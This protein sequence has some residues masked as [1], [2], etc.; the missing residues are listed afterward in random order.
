MPYRL[1]HDGQGTIIGMFEAGKNTRT[2]TKYSLV[3]KSTEDD[4]L[5]E[6]AKLAP[7][8]IY[9][10]SVK[11]PLL[12]K[13]LEPLADNQEATCLSWEILEDGSVKITY[14][15]QGKTYWRLAKDKVAGFFKNLFTRKS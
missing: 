14:G 9:I 5:A 1:I 4:C 15:V 7:K 10:D 3:E 8:E 12:N 2:Y 13:P 6:L 11:Y